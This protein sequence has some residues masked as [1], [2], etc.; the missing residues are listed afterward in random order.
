M[1]LASASAMGAE[2]IH[3]QRGAAFPRAKLPDDRFST[4]SQ[5]K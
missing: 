5:H 2:G 4:T 3:E 1:S